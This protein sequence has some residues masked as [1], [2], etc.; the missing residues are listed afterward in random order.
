[1]NK[2]YDFLNGYPVSK[3][4]LRKLFANAMLEGGGYRNHV[5]RESAVAWLVTYEMSIEQQMKEISGEEE[6][7]AP[8]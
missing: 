5:A 2:N 6:R 8:F 7:R 3:E 1:M 4:D